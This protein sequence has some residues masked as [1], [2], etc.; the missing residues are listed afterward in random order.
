MPFAAAFIAYLASLSGSVLFFRKSIRSLRRKQIIW[1]I[2]AFAFALILGSA[3]LIQNNY[4][5]KAESGPVA[6]FEDPLGPNVAFGE[7]RGI[8]PGRV[9]W[10]YNPNATNEDCTNKYHSDAYWLEKNT[11][12]DLVDQ[13]F[14]HGIK[15]LTGKDSHAEAWDAVFRY[16]N[17]NHKKGDT[18]F[19]ESFVLQRG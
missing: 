12:Q 5:A 14:S 6:L 15:S 13:M 3:S 17:Q 10:E 8:F 11:D 19:S 4:Y 7:A 1:G 2:G 16:F 18:I 9:V